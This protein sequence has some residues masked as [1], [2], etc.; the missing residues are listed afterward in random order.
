MSRLESLK[1]LT[2]AIVAD[3]KSGNFKDFFMSGINENS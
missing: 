2:T 1:K 3:V